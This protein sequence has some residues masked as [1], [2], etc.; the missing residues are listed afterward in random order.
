MPGVEEGVVVAQPNDWGHVALVAYVVSA[1]ERTLALSAL[2][3]F[4]GETLPRIY[5]PW[6]HYSFG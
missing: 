5:G 4:L 2:R 3:A 1:E 6:N